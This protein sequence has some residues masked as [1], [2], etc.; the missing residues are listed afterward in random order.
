VPA[1]SGR[2]ETGDGGKGKRIIP[3]RRIARMC[4]SWGYLFCFHVILLLGQDAP[5]L[6]AGGSVIYFLVRQGKGP[7]AGW[8]IDEARREAA[9]AAGWWRSG[10]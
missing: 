10:K 6:G 5:S 7:V 4:L 8:V 9:P 2:R 3:S 1:R